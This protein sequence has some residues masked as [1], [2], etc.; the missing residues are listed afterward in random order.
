MVTRPA[1]TPVHAGRALVD[2]LDELRRRYSPH[3][4]SNP[5]EFLSNSNLTHITSGVLV[6]GGAVTRGLGLLLCTGCGQTTW[7]CQVEGA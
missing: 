7:L 2:V 3:A 4:H 6:L 5:A 1:I